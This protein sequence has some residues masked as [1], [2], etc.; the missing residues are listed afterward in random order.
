MPDLSKSESRLNKAIVDLLECQETGDLNVAKWLAA[1]PIDL[2]PELRAFI[3]HRQMV[4]GKS[5]ASQGS[6]TVSQ[7]PEELAA[8]SNGSADTQRKSLDGRIVAGRYKLLK[9]IGAGGMGEVWMAEQREPVKRLVALKLIKAGHGSEHTLVRFEAE[10][11]ALA[12]MD[13]PS[14]AKVLDGGTTEEGQP[15]FIME[16]VKGIPITEYCDQERLTPRQRLELIIP[17]CQAVQHSHQ[18]GVIHRDLKPSNI[19]VALYDGKAVPKVIDF[20]IAKAINRDLTDNS[21]YTEV[22]QI[23]GTLKYMPPEQAELSNL[24]ID[25]RA[26]ELD[27]IV[28]KCLAKERSRRYETANGMAMD[29]KR[30]LAVEPVE[31]SPPSASYRLKKLLRRNKGKVIA[32]SL[33]LLALAGGIVGTSTGLV[34][35]ERARDGEAKQRAAAETNEAKANLAAK[36]ER[37][38][39]DETNRAREREL[40]KLYAADMLLASRAVIEGPLSRAFELLDAWLPER[41]DGKEYRG[42]EWH[43]LRR[44]C[45]SSEM[46]LNGHTGPLRALAWTTDGKRLASGGEDRVIRVWDA[47][48]GQCLD[49]LIGH[50]A[51]VFDVAF[52]PDGRMLVSASADATVRLWDVESGEQRHVLRGHI[53]PVYT[54]AF[55]PSGKQVASAGGD[56]LIKVWDAIGGTELFALQGHEAAVGRLQFDA[57]GKKLASS[58]VILGTRIWD[59]ESRKIVDGLNANGDI[60][61]TPELAMGIFAVPTGE[62]RVVDVKAKTVDQGN[63]GIKGIHA[64][65]LNKTARIVA[66][67]GSDDIIRVLD[68][69]SASPLVTHRGHIGPARRVLLRA[70]ARKLASAGDDGTVRIWDMP[71][72]NEKKP[73]S[74]HHEHNVT[75]AAF[76]TDGTFLASGDYLGSIAIWNSQTGKRELKLGSHYLRR[77]SDAKPL[78]IGTGKPF[79]AGS[80]IKNQTSFVANPSIKNPIVDVLVAQGHGGEVKGVAFTPDRKALVSAG[81]TDLIIWDLPSGKLLKE[82]EHPAIVS[83][84][85]VSPDGTLAATSCWDDIVRIFRVQSGDLIKQLEGHDDDVMCVAFHPNGR[86]LAT[87]SRDRTAIIW[88]IESGKIKHRLRQHAN[89]I[90]AIRFSPDGARLVTGGMDK[91]IHVWD[92]ATGKYDSTLHG[93]NEGVTSL[94]FSADGKWLLSASD[95]T[96]DKNARVWLWNDG[97]FSEGALLESFG[98]KGPTALAVHPITGD[99][100]VGRTQLSTFVTKSVVQAPATI[101][102]PI[103]SEILRAKAPTDLRLRVL[104]YALVDEIAAWPD[105]EK[106]RLKASR[107][108]GRFLVIAASL[109]FSRLKLS[110]KAYQQLLEL[111]RKEDTTEPLKFSSILI[112]PRNFILAN[113]QEGMIPAEFVGRI[114]KSQNEGFEFMKKGVPMLENMTATPQRD[115]RELVYLG[116]EVAKDF[117]M[118]DLSLRFESDDPVPVPSLELTTFRPGKPFHPGSRDF[119]AGEGGS[120]LRSNV[121]RSPGP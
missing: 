61:F 25:T 67:S 30:Y 41:R 29:I 13:H 121:L 120:R 105:N 43:M 6:G 14:I 99:P 4:V 78:E 107:P 2:Q 104:G 26:G 8:I 116:W 17:V 80:P 51:G 100:L 79:V 21:M 57:G 96:E 83:S 97:R 119:D 89:T 94:A 69:E 102:E 34:R 36:T 71:D 66:I 11:Q 22:G 106:N 53:L 3:E 5:A 60:V 9:M 74:G 35:A 117:S 33:L 113:G 62:F 49:T 50:S 65:G 39:K 73:H 87:G 95:E 37:E 68:R 72:P 103:T 109:P 44:L 24:D 91:T 110:D 86:E 64:V 84:L 93:H 59:L 115:A 118:K 31:A 40:R 10:R 52:S 16:L 88:D 55:H 75:A 20:G 38:A 85:A 15:Y 90:S 1:Q 92:A 77:K 27:W 45:D 23:V 18:K 76:S 54:V 47:E 63:I 12:M 82:F 58:G 81:A 46:T 42:R 28:M 114:A 56:S 98:R 7:T 48:S 19:L 108:G 70:D 32:A 111:K 112:T 101:A